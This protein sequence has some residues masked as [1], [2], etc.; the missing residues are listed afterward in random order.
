MRV[1]REYAF[2]NI[3]RSIRHALDREVLRAGQC[4]FAQTACE[5][6]IGHQTSHC[7]PERGGIRDVREKTGF[8]VFDDFRDSAGSRRRDWNSESQRVEQHGSHAFLA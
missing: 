8:A 5:R 2:V 7:I 3:D 1:V 4:V 6:W